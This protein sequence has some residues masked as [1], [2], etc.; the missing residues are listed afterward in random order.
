MSFQLQPLDDE[1]WQLVF[2]D[3]PEYV[4]PLHMAPESRER[5]L[6]SGTWLIVTFPVWSGP[7]RHSVVA[8]VAC[9]RD[10]GGTFQLGVRPFDHHEEIYKWWPSSKAPSQA[11][12]RIEVRE[13][14]SRREVHIS[15]D[16]AASPFWLVLRDGQVLYQGAG[17]RSSA[18]LRELMQGVLA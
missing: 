5:E 6:D 14:S 11:E 8:A 13:E 7:V 9:A 1:K 2:T 15:T 3:E 18:Q 4:H 17:P 12:V 10:F 16:P